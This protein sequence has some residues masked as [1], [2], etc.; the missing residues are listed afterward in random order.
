MAGASQFIAEIRKTIGKGKGDIIPNPSKKGGYKIPAI[1]NG[2]GTLQV[3]KTDLEN[4]QK[5]YPKH[6]GNATIGKGE[7]ALF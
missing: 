6:L 1:S 3:A 4:F 2:A 7:E 5:L